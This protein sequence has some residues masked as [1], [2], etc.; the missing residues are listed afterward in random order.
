MNV[1]NANWE[2]D[3]SNNWQ[4][5]DAVSSYPQ[6]FNFGPYTD[7]DYVEV[8]RAAVNVTDAICVSGWIK[9]QTNTSQRQVVISN[10]ESTN[11]ANNGCWS[12]QVGDGWS[13]GYTKMEFWCRPASEAAVFDVAQTSGQVITDNKWHHVV[14]LWDGTTTTNA[15]K[16]F[17]DGLLAGQGTAPATAPIKTATTSRPSMGRS[18]SDST[19]AYGGGYWL[20]GSGKNGYLSNVQVW[21]SA[22]TYGS[23]SSI[24]DAATGQIAELYNNGS[25]LTTAIE[26][27]NLKLWAKLDNSATFSTNWSIP[28]ASGNGNTGTSSGMT[29]QNL[30]NNNVSALNGT[31]NG[32][33]TANLVNSDLTRS[34]PYSSYSMEFDGTADHIDCGATAYLDNLTEMSCS[35]WFNLDT[36]AINKGLIDD[37]DKHFAIYTKSVSGSDYSFRININGSANR[38]NITGTPF[39]AGQWHH[40]VM[41][42]NAGTL[43]FYADGIVVGSTVYSGSIPTSLSGTTGNL[44]I[45]TYGTLYWDGKISNA[46][47]FNAVLTQD[48][49]L[50]IYNGGVP[51]SISSL[52][53]IGW[54]SLAGDSYF[55]G[56]DWICPRL[57]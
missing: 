54:W 12:F 53:P 52:S 29:E 40:L 57:R 46:A 55:N 50:T 21:D 10:Y 48:Q 34:I 9:T 22:L 2:A 11:V 7:Y 32:M 17:V 43:T 18:A 35:I 14:A 44:D 45:G 20:G 36:S 6:S 23:V 33:T 42:F 13:S 30:V 15:V 41:T 28:D 3:T 31:S 1:D 56:S 8:P 27:S 5:A 51:N 25:P 16:I 19:G 4:I 24:G 39:T 26:S 37:N 47:I 38:V 49:V